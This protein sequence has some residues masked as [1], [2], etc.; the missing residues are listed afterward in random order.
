MS[1]ENINLIGKEQIIN[2]ISLDDIKDDLTNNL[3]DSNLIFSILV[4]ASRNFYSKN[5]NSVYLSNKYNETSKSNFVQDGKVIDDNIISL[6]SDSFTYFGNLSG[7]SSLNKGNG[8][9]KPIV[10][11]LHS[12]RI[13]MVNNGVRMQDQEWGAE[14]APN[15]DI[16]SVGRL[17]LIKSASALQY[18]GD[19]M[20]GVII[21][22]A[23]K[24]PVKDSLYGKTMTSVASNGR[25]GILT[26]NLT[27]SYSSG[28][29]GTAQSTVKRFGDF[30][31]AD[32]ILSNTGLIEQNASLHLGLNKFNYGFEGYFSFFSNS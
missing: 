3:K 22:E 8:I 6:A 25:G 16:N 11:G 28:W 10:N 20:G 9:V 13:I 17:T 4:L 1:L 30:E 29:F 32:Y 15:I 26:S 27:K 24:V 2:T 7:V 12:S 31:A 18:G 21:A 23:L 5:K 14:H 19:A